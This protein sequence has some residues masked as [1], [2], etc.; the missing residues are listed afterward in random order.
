M[1][2][3]LLLHGRQPLR[4][5][6]EHTHLSPEQVR[7][8]LV[9][10]IQQH[11][12]YHSA[13]LDD[14]IT[15]YDANWKSAYALVRSGKITQLVEERLGRY[16]AEVM[17]VILNLG[18]VKVSDLEDMPE[19]LSSAAEKGPPGTE[20]NGLNGVRGGQDH[21]PIHA[22]SGKGY[23]K[24]KRIADGDNARANVNGGHGDSD[25]R[26]L[27][28]TLRQLAGYGYIMRVRDAHFRSPADNFQAAHD[29]AKASP[30]VQSL[31]GKKLQDAIDE[32][33]QSLLKEWLDGT[34]L[35][36]VPFNGPPRR[37]KRRMES[38]SSPGHAR[39]RAKLE[40]VRSGVDVDRDTDEDP[41]ADD[42]DD[43]DDV[44]PMDVS[45][46]SSRIILLCDLGL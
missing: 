42:D 25:L 22:K 6:A 7:H 11:L 15:Y 27:H 46:A 16:A 20:V 33:T 13:S 45:S 9:V 31:K 23:G 30:S 21:E 40:D 2:S 43:D 37:I 38:S 41:E 32:A 5:I 18:H 26:R 4:K 44:A 34:I 29:A 24:R 3:Y 17:S 28:R 14:G 12:I 8:G 36:G 39:K 1:F 35:R 10:L 19:L